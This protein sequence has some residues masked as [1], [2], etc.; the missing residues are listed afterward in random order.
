MRNKCLVIAF[1]ISI[2]ACNTDDK[3]MLSE[4]VLSEYLEINA[5]QLLD[6]VIACAASDALNPENVWVYYY[7]IIGSTDYRYFETENAAVDPNDFS[8]YTRKS[9]TETPEFGGKLSKFLRSS[10]HEAWG[11]VT[12]LSQGK[13]HKS[14]PIRLKQNTLPTSYSTAISIDETQPTT[15]KFSWEAS[16]SNQDAIYF[17]ALVANAMDFISGTYTFERCFR[18]YDT[19]NVVLDI[20]TE[21]PPNLDETAA[22]TINILGVS[23]DNWVNLHLRKNF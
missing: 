12:F 14:N 10:A 22:Y 3:I 5:D 21:V 18:Y 20:N 15:P 11:V 8:N 13:I 19:D 6:E 17:Q 2:T 4:D 23:A 16:A 7:P 1:I 9:L